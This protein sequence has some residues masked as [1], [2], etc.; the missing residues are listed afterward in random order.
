LF[1][2]CGILT[3]VERKDYLRRVSERLITFSDELTVYEASK[4][5]DELKEQK[6]NANAR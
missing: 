5:I 3:H 6:D 4:V 2:D 1:I